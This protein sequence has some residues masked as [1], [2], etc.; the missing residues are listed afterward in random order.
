MDVFEYI[1]TYKTIKKDNP[2]FNDCLDEMARS[3]SLC[4]KLNDKRP[5]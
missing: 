2:L 3:H 5:V 4:Q 1:D